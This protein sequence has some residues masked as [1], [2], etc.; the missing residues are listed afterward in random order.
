MS[1]IEAA[2]EDNELDFDTLDELRADGEGP[3]DHPCPLCGPDRASEFNRTRPTLR[4][5]EPEPGFITYYCARC[6]AK[7]YAHAGADQTIRRPAVRASQ[8]K[9]PPADDTARLIYVERIWSKAWCDL[10]EKVVAYFVSRG[11]HFN[12]VPRGVLR[13]H[14]ECPWHGK[15][16]PCILARFT[17]ALTG[18]PRGIWRR[19]YDE[20]PMTLG[21]MGGCVIRLFPEIGK[22]LVVAEGVETALT[23]ATRMM[24]RGV[25][26]HPGWATGCAGNLRRLPVLDGVKQLV[27]LVDNDRS[28]TGQKAAE[29]CAQRSS[30][31]G[32]KVIRLMP[33][34][35]GLDFNDL[36]S[37]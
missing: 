22:R 7:G 36:V 15:N 10:P 17:D 30:A 14:P 3:L 33:K 18:E 21:P 31:A 6:E 37:S 9:V 34:G 27:I 23:A 28:G 20:K 12:E 11:I 4:T 32:R 26:L 25:P 5:W 8:P 13:F 35:E 29:E 16:L 24:H 2:Q 19:F 1:S